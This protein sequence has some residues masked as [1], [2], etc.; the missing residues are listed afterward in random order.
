MYAKR[1]LLLLISLY[2]FVAALPAVCFSATISDLFNTGVNN[3]GTFLGEGILDPHYTL[4]SSPNAGY[5]LQTVTPVPVSW[6]AN[7]NDSAWLG[8]GTYRSEASPGIYLFETTFTLEAGADLSTV[9]LEGKIAADNGFSIFLNGEDTLISNT[10]II[11]SNYAELTEF[12]ISSGFLSGLNTL[13]F[14]VNN[15]GHGNNPMGLRIDDMTGS[16][17]MSDT[18]PV[19]EPASFMLLGFGLLGLAGICRKK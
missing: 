14:R 8:I 18:S 17:D 4:V 9:L 10:Y 2:V 3:S 13:Q 16:Y 19:P 12:S 15:G 1:N 11:A 7:D 6:V 5:N